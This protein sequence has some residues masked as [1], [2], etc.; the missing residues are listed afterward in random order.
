M[1]LVGG[2]L[3]TEG[4]VEICL[5]KLWGLVATNGWGDKDAAVVCRQLDFGTAGQ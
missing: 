5:D 1:R 2:D 3:P 4:T